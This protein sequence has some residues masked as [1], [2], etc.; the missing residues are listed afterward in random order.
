MDDVKGTSASQSKH[1]VVQHHVVHCP[2]IGDIN[3]YVQVLHTVE[4]NGSR[5]NEFE[6][7]AFRL[8]PRILRIDDDD[9]D[10]DDEV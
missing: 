7:S 2:N 6:M 4:C 9:N 5:P 1:H 3:V 10:D 8:P